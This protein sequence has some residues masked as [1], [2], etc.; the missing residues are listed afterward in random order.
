MGAILT[1]NSVFL[2]VPKTGGNRIIEI[3]RAHG[4]IKKEFDHKHVE[5]CRMQVIEKKVF[6]KNP[7]I[8]CCVRHPITWYESWYRYQKKR[9]F[10]GWGKNNS[11]SAIY[12]PCAIIDDCQDEDFNKFVEN[13][14]NKY[15]G[16]VSNMYFQF[17]RNADLIGKQES[18]KEFLIMVMNF[19]GFEIDF[20]IMNSI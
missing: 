2:H 14:L 1:N 9:K 18:L 16:F 6:S 11:G 17:T 7:F 3:L 8:F 12:H 15:P 19:L 4:K 20:N 13:I 10:K 5:A